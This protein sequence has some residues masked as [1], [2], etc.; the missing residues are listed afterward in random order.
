MEAKGAKVIETK[1]LA[2]VSH[3]RQVGAC[4]CPSCQGQTRNIQKEQKEKVEI[5]P[6]Y[7]S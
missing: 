6:N 2:G 4:D 1:K 5:G 7:Y 3:L